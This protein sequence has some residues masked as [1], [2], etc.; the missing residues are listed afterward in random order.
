MMSLR[1][2]STI[3]PWQNTSRGPTQAV[4][5]TE[6]HQLFDVMII[7]A[8]ITGL[9]TALLLQQ[10]G[11]KCIVI[12]NGSL[13]FGTTGGTS[14]H[15]NTFFDTTYPEIESDFGEKEAKM[16]AAAGKE[17]IEL[18]KHFTDQLAIS[19]DLAEKKAY[20]FSQNE[21]QS[22][23]LMQILAASQ[24]AG[25]SVNEIAEINLPVP[26]QSAIL[27]HQQGQFHP[28]K[29]LHG[30]ADSFLKLGGTLCENTFITDVEKTG[31]LYF[32]NAE[33]QLFKA[34]N[35]VYATHAVPGVNSFS[36]KCAPYRSYV[37][38]VRLADEN[39]PDDLAYDMME[40]YHYFR[41]HE[42][43]GKKY[44]LVGGEDHKTGQ[45]DPEESFNALEAYVKQYYDVKEV[46][47]RWSSQYYIPA[48]GLPYIG[49]MPGEDNCFV[50]TGYNGNGMIF[51]T[52]AGK[53]ISDEILGIENEYRALF[54]PS[55]LKPIAGFSEL[56]Q[57]NVNVAWH[58]IAD[59]FKSEAID[60]LNDLPNGTGTIAVFKGEKL[61]IYKDETGSVSLL[62]PVCT[63]AG[64]IVNY[65]A[66][67]KS[68][69]CPCHGGRFDMHGNILCGPP[70]KNLTKYK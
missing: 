26:F 49:Q 20:L 23:Q 16:V 5:N 39:Y 34:S 70:K 43:E 57:E 51:G 31:D 40:P 19:C 32:A 30:L 15:L 55:R 69:D 28:I 22:K 13:G 36:F 54:S 56:V 46:T 12:E 45:G 38:G 66:A 8:G 10:Q 44:L 60:T 3:S 7:G 48:D 42:I 33:L 2:S 52:L 53:I 68:W 18:I 29:Y 62:D 47:Y 17:A 58:F 27:F 50:A 63:H 65:N 11:K 14:A 67:E 35:L 41:T 6:K 37:I 59:R 61:A 25:I 9:T 4:S 64:C 1:D 21:Q 24:R